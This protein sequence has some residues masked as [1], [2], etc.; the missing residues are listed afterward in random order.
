MLSARHCAPGRGIQRRRGAQRRVNEGT[1]VALKGGQG[2][3]IGEQQ[4]LESQ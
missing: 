3:H 4:V 2:G 1:V